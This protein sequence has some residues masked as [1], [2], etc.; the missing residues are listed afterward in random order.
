[1]IGELEI[2]STDYM[3]VMCPCHCVNL[4][5]TVVGRMVSLCLGN[6]QFGGDGATNS[7]MV[8]KKIS[9]WM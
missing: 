5:F 6:T 4:L 3:A 9:K 8:Q 7:H 2:K 1:M